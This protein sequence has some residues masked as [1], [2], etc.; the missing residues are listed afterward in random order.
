MRQDTR[1]VRA[2]R[3]L[4]SVVLTHMIALFMTEEGRAV[5]HFKTCELRHSHVG[6]T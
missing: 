4:T 5:V 1:T 2:V 3:R 6:S